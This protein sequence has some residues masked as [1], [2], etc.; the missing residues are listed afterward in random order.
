MRRSASAC[1]AIV[2]LVVA[3]TAA[4]GS[5][6]EAC[7]DAHTNAQELRAQKRLNDAKADL[8]RCV[9]TQCPAPIRRDCAE[10]LEQV[11]SEIPTVVF[12][13]R[14]ASGADVLGVKVDV[15]GK[16]VSD[17]L[18]GSA[19]PLDPG[20]RLVRFVLPDG[21]KLE[22]KVLLREGEH[23]REVGITLEPAAAAPKPASAA[24]P[25]PSPPATAPPGQAAPAHADPMPWVFA[26]IGVVGLASFSF[27]SLSG[28]SKQNDLETCAPNCDRSRQGDYDA[29]K[30][31]YLIGDI[32]LG[33]GVA[34]LA[35]GAV[36]LLESRSSEK[37]GA[38][39]GGVRL[40]IT[41]SGVAASGNF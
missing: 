41:P 22:K 21:K 31:D 12:Y 1:V 34:S 27:F 16:R 19:I 4:A 33:V 20:T 37:A 2:V 14:D 35:A 28:R 9:A 5:A 26:G 24:H 32:S 39:R 30:R 23:L 10:L 18:D 11:E 40:G 29:M 6:T 25:P 36:W 15:D 17:R 38:A 7:I 8:G 13:V 3:K